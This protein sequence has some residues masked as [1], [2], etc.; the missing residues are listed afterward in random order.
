MSKKRHGL[1]NSVVS[2]VV[3]KKSCIVIQDDEEDFTGNEKVTADD[4]NLHWTGKV[5]KLTNKRHLV[6]QL[7]CQRGLTAEEGKKIDDP[8][9]L[10]VTIDATPLPNT[11]PVIYVDDDPCV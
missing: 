9:N 10:S 3:T 6:V 8:G 11:V 4:G 1:L 2:R 5:L 7:T